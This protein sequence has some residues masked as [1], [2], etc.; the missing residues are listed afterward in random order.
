MFAIIGMT[1]L[2]VGDR[3]RA[4]DQI[5]QQ[6]APTSDGNNVAQVAE[7]SS[8]A[9]T[10]VPTVTPIPTPTSVDPEGPEKTAEN[11]LT[12]WQNGDYAAMYTMLTAT[13][14]KS[15]SQADFVARY[16]GIVDK[17]SLTKVK[18]S[19]M[20][21][22]GLD[23]KVPYQITFTSA[24]VGD[25]SEK[26]SI[27]VIQEG[28]RWAVSWTPSLIF[29]ELGTDGCIDFEG[30]T[31]TRGKILDRNGKVLAEDQPFAQ[32]GVDVGEVVDPT[33]YDELGPVIG[34]SANDIRDLV[35]GKPANWRVPLK[36]MP[37]DKSTD[38]LNAVKGIPGATVT[39]TSTRAYPYK[40][41]TAQV[42]GWVSPATEEDIKNDTTGTIQANQMLGRTGLEYGANDLLAGKPGGQLDVVN[43]DSRSVVKVLA[44]R[45]PTPSSDIYL[46][47]DVAFQKSVDQALTAQVKGDQRSAAVILDPQTGAVLAMVSHPSFDPNG[48]VTGV[49][50]TTDQRVL[51]DDLLRASVNRA[52]DELYPTGSIFK[53]ITTSAAMHYLNY[54]A[55]TQI[56]C[57]SSFSIGDQTWDDWVVDYGEPPQGELTLHEGLV[58]S[59]NTVFYQVGQK[60]DDKNPEDLPDMAKAYGLGSK[61]G[62]D[63]LPE[64]AGTIPDPAW[65]EKNIG[66]GWSTGDAVNMAIG[67]GYVQATPLQMANVYASIA[68]GG[69]LLT[70]YIVDKTKKQ[71]ETQTVQVGKRVERGKIPLNAEQ[72]GQ[73]QDMLKDQTSNQNNEGSAKV[74]LGFDFDISGKTGT[75]ENTLDGSGDPHSWFAAYG[76]GRDTAPTIASCVMFENKGEGVSFAAP[77]TKAIYTAYEK[78]SLAKKEP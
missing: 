44:A 46:T 45:D 65:K 18:A 16:Q 24:L 26:N 7:T 11:W 8:P 57:P 28:S 17:A 69:H 36:N 42:V 23:G 58:Q 31:P 63:Y 64:V 55:D 66:D 72:M 14:Q 13:S 70:P 35:Q 51:N 53:V 25:I 41:L 43:C 12:A 3:L 40:A 19:I 73:L 32:V 15:I 4:P 59:C 49:F 47:L 10:D 54:T 71:G 52:S 48:Y 62:I 75:A 56:D 60:L 50:S 68:N 76:P 61:T 27:P 21:Q 67:Q 30:T 9:P 6:V 77:A 29:K 22:P 20:G 78:S 38:L 5:V 74:F 34:M 33:T 1:A 2:L 39:S 37:A